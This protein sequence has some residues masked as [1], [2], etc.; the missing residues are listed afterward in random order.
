MSARRK[1]SPEQESAIIDWYSQ[2]QQALSELRK[3][4]SIHDKARAHGISLR[5]LHTIVKRDAYELRRKCKAAGI[6]LHAA[7]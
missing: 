3:L 1:L 5:S 4:G 2:Y 7:G 6:D